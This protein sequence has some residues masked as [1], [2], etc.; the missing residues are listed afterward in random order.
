M[1]FMG[2]KA[3]AVTSMD[4]AKL[5]GMPGDWG[6]TCDF[7]M[8]DLSTVMAVM[9]DCGESSRFH[10]ELPGG[11]WDT[12]IAIDGD[13][14]DHLAL[15]DVTQDLFDNITIDYVPSLTDTV[16]HMWG[17]SILPYD[18][19]FSVNTNNTGAGTSYHLTPSVL[20]VPEPSTLLLLGS[21]LVGVFFYGRKKFFKKT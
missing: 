13:H 17:N 4:I 8:T 3:F 11:W 1:V 20:P 12:E 16:I 21:G 9:P 6:G 10:V 18:T 2:S 14:T 19:Y 5:P 7:D 15:S